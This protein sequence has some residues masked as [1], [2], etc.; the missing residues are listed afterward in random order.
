MKCKKFPKQQQTKEFVCS[1]IQYGV[2]LVNG[3]KGPSHTSSSTSPRSPSMMSQS[4]W[5]SSNVDEILIVHLAMVQSRQD[6]WLTGWHHTIP[7]Q[8]WNPFIS[9]KEDSCQFGTS[10]TDIE[11]MVTG[12]C[13]P[14]LCL[15]FP[16]A[17]HIWQCYT[18]FLSFVL[19]FR[20]FLPFIM[21]PKHK[22]DFRW[23]SFQENESDT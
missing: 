21:G 11:V 12:Y 8:G 3:N 23:Q 5:A 7:C 13:E 6:W 18:H 2:E 10:R 16:V 19:F 1:T 22:S 4:W 20:N 17:H 15:H 14:S 9:S